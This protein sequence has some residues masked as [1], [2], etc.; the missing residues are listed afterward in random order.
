MGAG[1]FGFLINS[2]LSLY[3]MQGLSL[4]S[5]HAHTTLLGVYGKLG[6][7]LLLFCLRGAKPVAVL[8]ETLLRSTFWGLNT[9]IALMAILTLLPLGTIQLFASIEHG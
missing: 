5:L 1:L 4:T 8:S 7:G 3:Y 2:T 9:G 6:I